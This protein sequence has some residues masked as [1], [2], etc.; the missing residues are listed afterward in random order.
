[1]GTGLTTASLPVVYQIVCAFSE[2]KV[3][4]LISWRT[5]E[6]A[7][8]YRITVKSG[9]TVVGQVDAVYGVTGTI[10]V[11]QG[12][13]GE[14]YLL[15]VEATDAPS[16]GG[17]TIVPA[18]PF[19]KIRQVVAENA[20]SLALLYEASDCLI[21]K[22]SVRIL[23]K[24]GITLA[25][26]T[27][28][29]YLDTFSLRKSG[30]MGVES[31]DLQLRCGYY[32]AGVLVWQDYGDEKIRICMEQPR[33][34]SLQLVSDKDTGWKGSFS[35]TYDTTSDESGAA[36]NM[37]SD[38]AVTVHDA[39]S[40]TPLLYLKQADRYLA[41]DVEKKEDAQE[42][43]FT[44][45]AEDAAEV[46]N[47][48]IFLKVQK[49]VA[50]SLASLMERL[51]IE[52]PRIEAEYLDKKQW[53]C[54]LQEG[55]YGRYQALIRKTDESLVRENF[56][57]RK[58]TADWDGVKSV[59]IACQSHN[60]IG[61]FT[62]EILMERPL[63][64]WNNGLLYRDTLPGD[65]Q[66]GNISLEL[67]LSQFEGSITQGAFSLS[68]AQASE[69]ETDTVKA[70][71]T[72]SSSVWETEEEK[73]ETLKQDYLAFI[74]LAAER[75]TSQT[76]MER[77]MQAVGDVMP[78]LPEEML[79]YQG[80]YLEHFCLLKKDMGVRVT[81]GQYHIVEDRSGGDLQYYNGFAGS[82]TE[83]YFLIRRGENLT[84]EPF[85]YLLANSGYMCGLQ[86]P[87]YGHT[88]VE[89]GAGILDFHYGELFSPW[90]ALYYPDSV[91]R[92]D[93]QGAQKAQD[94]ECL[95]AA[96]SLQYLLAGIEDLY[97]KGYAEHMYSMHMRGRAHFSPL[98]RIWINGEKRYVV[99][100]TQLADMMSEQEAGCEELII[101]RHGAVYTA[102]IL[103]REDLLLLPLMHEDE[104]EVIL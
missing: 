37:A 11:A 13:E 6:E 87:S 32:S 14:R 63:Y 97:E 73:R 78:M 79:W 90:L 33:L 29:G 43:T 36:C 3:R 68:A 52:T 55:S 12:K 96:E 15:S 27:V 62:E 48:G 22:S 59:K 60:G 54:H 50:L 83:D 81:Y 17:G 82:S 46:D 89:G 58:F 95:T 35:Y 51:V 30:L 39:T 77:L 72:L 84:F 34:T 94:N 4:Y 64:Q 86:Q 99:L 44:L 76:D 56:T 16:S 57:G 26:Q 93:M 23:D 21:E 40:E 98:I 9:D 70:V 88:A 91:I 8:P 20:E 5:D 18:R 38:T 28:D 80:G 47:E 100:G 69:Q 1:M 65:G 61:P 101:R 53:V 24:E 92:L 41:L 7:G 2:D 19:M 75:I 104:V 85:L 45:S 31:F 66:A 67:E 102:G 25:E 74:K 10:T 49:G 103:G 71:L 42:G